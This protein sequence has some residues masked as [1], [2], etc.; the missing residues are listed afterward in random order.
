MRRFI[1]LSLLLSL[2]LPAGMRAQAPQGGRERP[3][4][5]LRALRAEFENELTGN[6]LPFWIE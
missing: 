4:M 2:L 5:R 1:L 6:I 3:D